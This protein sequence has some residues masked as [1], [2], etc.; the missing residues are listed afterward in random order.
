MRHPPKGNRKVERLCS[1]GGV[2]AA[3][4]PEAFLV[5]E[6]QRK[7]LKCPPCYFTE[8]AETVPSALRQKIRPLANTG[9]V[10]HLP[11]MICW[12]PHHDTGGQNSR[13]VSL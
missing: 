7:E 6:V 4:F 5:D 1:K 2:D 3:D 10:Q 12:R 11:S 8:T 9:A 13:S